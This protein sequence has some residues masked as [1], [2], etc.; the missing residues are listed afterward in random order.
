MKK[1]KSIS[2]LAPGW[3]PVLSAVILLVRRQEIRE[4]LV[5]RFGMV[6]CSVVLCFGIVFWYCVS[7]LCFGIVFQ[8]FGF[9]I[10]VFLL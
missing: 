9:G 3:L 2:K 8:Y 1:F 10:P 4:N 5:F 6:F 7:V